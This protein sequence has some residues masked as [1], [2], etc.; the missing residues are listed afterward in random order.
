[1]PDRRLSLAERQFVQ[2][3]IIGLTPLIVA[4]ALATAALLTRWWVDRQ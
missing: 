2:H 3:V 1:L 4:V